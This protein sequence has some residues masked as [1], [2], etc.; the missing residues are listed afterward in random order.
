MDLLHTGCRTNLI[1]IE[2]EDYILQINGRLTNFK[3]SNIG[4]NT[5]KPA[6][7][8]VEYN[9]TNVS[10][11][12]VTNNGTMAENS[13]I[14]MY[15]CF[16]EDESYDIFIKIKNNS[17]VR[18][19][20]I[21]EEIRNNI[22]QMMDCLVG[23]FSFKGEIGQ[24]VFRIY[25]DN[26][27]DL[28]LIIE[29]FPAKMDYMDDYQNM[30]NE[31][32]EE[33]ASLAFNFLGSTQHNSTLVE[34][35]NQ[36]NTEFYNIL[37]SIFDNLMKSL[38]KIAKS[39]KHSL[40]T[41]ERI[42]D[43]NKSNRVSKNTLNY[44]NKHPEMLSKSN[45]GILINGESYLPTKI[46]EE[47]KENTIDI[48]E[49]RFIKY[50]INSILKRLTIIENNLEDKVNKNVSSAKTYIE[51]ISK[52]KKQLKVH[53]NLYY[54][55]IGDIHGKTTMSLV[56]KMTSGYKE[57]FYYYNVLKKGL[58]LSEDIYS[59]TPKK[60]YN[61]YEIW[62]YI[63]LHNIIEELGYKVADYGI[64][65]VKDNGL[66]LSLLQNQ[67]ALMTYKNE[68]GDEVQLWYN[69]VYKNLPTTAQKPDTVLC[70]KNKNSTDDRV[71]IFDAKY[72][73][74][75]KKGVVGP[76]EEDINVMHRY[77]D[78]IVSQFGDNH[79][80]KYNTF[81]AYV[82]FPYSNEKEYMEH[83]F[84][85]SIDKVNIG[86][87]PML[88]GSYELIKKHIY[89]IINESSIEAKDRVVNNVIIEDN[90]YKYKHKN[91][92]VVNVKDKKHLDTYIKNE[93][94][95]IP[96]KHLANVKSDIKYV[97][98]YKPHGEDRDGGIQ[99]YAKIKEQKLYKRNECIELAKN[100]E[101][102][103]LRLELEEIQKINHIKSIE[104]GVRLIMYTT[105]YLL[106]NADNIHQLSF[107]SDEEVYVYRRLRKIANDMELPFVRKKDC[108]M[109]G[110]TKIEVL[111]NK[112]IYIN[113]NI[114]KYNE[115][116]DI[117]ISEA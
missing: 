50:V 59:I 44:I 89:T 30:M 35:T 2:T 12:T 87:L 98:F 15:P 93:F 23:S 60:I 106:K 37:K 43:I 82:M 39:P 80:F 48:Y 69:K 78:S 36:T 111:E 83:Q 54:K 34:V 108:Y 45:K 103:Y 26:N 107:R 27:I 90:N 31:I 33:I 92:I 84:Y 32:N 56:F 7:F 28:E 65:N 86:G 29:V 5:N 10:I 57:V 41:Y 76:H 49:N 55:H 100:S 17:N 68:E 71:Y 4:I 97:A 79:H 3:S 22:S 112:D 62:C 9:K 110:K 18:I 51:I 40:Y 88:P 67:E 109:V 38:N 11:K 105:L 19:Y 14:T 91:V 63:K 53:L 115:I 81:G 72:R 1:E 58:D 16:F 85:K 116:D 95:H 64:I 42:R 74:S 113:G 101:D 20:H 117:E 73:V 6:F 70:L 25:K 13:G 47:K 104:Y 24:S 21:S 96:S 99:Y 66:S 75:I 77:R 8:K 94:F 46:I 114:I 102:E 61:L 52:F